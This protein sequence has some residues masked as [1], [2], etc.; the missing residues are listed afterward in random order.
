MFVAFMNQYIIVYMLGMFT[1][2][3]TNILVCNV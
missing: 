2:V 1:Y 3:Y